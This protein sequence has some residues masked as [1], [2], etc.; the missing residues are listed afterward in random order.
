MVP[1]ISYLL[2]CNYQPASQR[3]KMTNIYYCSEIHTSVG[4]FL[5]LSEAD[6]Q[7]AGQVGGSVDRSWAHSQ[8]CFEGSWLQAQQSVASAETNCLTTRW[9]FILQQARQDLFLGWWQGSNAMSRSTKGLLAKQGQ[10]KNCILL[11]KKFTR[12]VQIQ[13][14]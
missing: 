4:L 9:S 13:K 7:T 10:W 3:L 5:C 14:K 1:C 12:L 8:I 6:Q 2:L 11:A